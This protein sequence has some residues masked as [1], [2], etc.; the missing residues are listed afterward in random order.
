M[1]KWLRIFIV[2]GFFSLVF[3]LMTIFF[4]DLLIGTAG[5]V[6]LISIAGIIYILIMK[7]TE[8]KNQKE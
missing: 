2:A 7:N 3:M 8:K 4:P 5:I 6:L 1:E